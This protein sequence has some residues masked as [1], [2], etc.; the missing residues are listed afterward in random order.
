MTGKTLIVFGLKK[1]TDITGLENLIASHDEHAMANLPTDAV[2]IVIARMHA[3]DGDTA[4]ILKKRD[5]SCLR[6]LSE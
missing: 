6:S 3:A 2:A 4:A 1:H 5:R